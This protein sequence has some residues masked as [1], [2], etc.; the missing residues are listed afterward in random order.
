VPS[1]RAIRREIRHSLSKGSNSVKKDGAGKKREDHLGEGKRD[2]DTYADNLREGRAKRRV[3]KRNAAR[4]DAAKQHL[5]G[6]RLPRQVKK[7]EKT[8]SEKKAG[9]FLPE[10]GEEDFSAGQARVPMPAGAIRGTFRSQQRRKGFKKRCRTHQKKGKEIERSKGGT[11]PV[12]KHLYHE[13]EKKGKKERGGGGERHQKR[14]KE[15][16]DVSARKSPRCTTAPGLGCSKPV[17]GGGPL[18]NQ[19]KR[20]LEFRKRTVR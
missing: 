17:P 4:E 18:R 1:S 15:R 7:K 16:K 6:T 20:L 8:R 10:K 11:L 5:F 13:L 19:K 9:G 2:P 12:T 3:Q 14:R